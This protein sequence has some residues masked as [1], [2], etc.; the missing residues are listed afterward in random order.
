MNIVGNFNHAVSI[1]SY[2]IFEFNYKR[3]LPLTKYLLHIVSY[4][5]EGDVIFAMF[6]RVFLTVR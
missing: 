4:T 2:W 5:L 1:F 3:T 6:E